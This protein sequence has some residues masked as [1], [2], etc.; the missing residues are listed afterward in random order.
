[1]RIIAVRHAESLY[2]AVYWARDYKKD[3]NLDR[4]MVDAPLTQ[5]GSNQALAVSCKLPP[6]LT[7]VVVSPLVRSI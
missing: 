2:N 7:H 1:M 6:Q 5:N 4:D 3:A